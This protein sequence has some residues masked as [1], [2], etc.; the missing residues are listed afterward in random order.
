MG[1]KAK[2]KVKVKKRKLKLKRIFFC[3]IFD[4]ILKRYG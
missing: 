4:L 1:K 2:V 3:L